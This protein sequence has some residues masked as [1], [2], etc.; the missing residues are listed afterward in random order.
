ME[1]IALNLSVTSEFSK[2]SDK[3]NGQETNDIEYFEFKDVKGK[4]ELNESQVFNYINYDNECNMN[5]LLIL[6]LSKFRKTICT[7]PLIF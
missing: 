2:E 6:C 4:L 5:N 7:K 1:N 3:G